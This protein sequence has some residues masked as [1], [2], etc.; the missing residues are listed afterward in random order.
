MT[1][2]ATPVANRTLTTR[3]LAGLRDDGILTEEEFADKKR[4][5]LARL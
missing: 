1:W 2:K 5:L 3:E 4:E